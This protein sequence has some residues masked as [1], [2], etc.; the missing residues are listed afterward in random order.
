MPPIGKMKPMIKITLPNGH[1]I[2]K[3]TRKEIRAAIDFCPI[4]RKE[5]VRSDDP[6]AAGTARNSIAVRND[7]I[8]SGESDR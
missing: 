2:E 6:D 5:N 4:R 8:Q 7:R 3:P 1:I